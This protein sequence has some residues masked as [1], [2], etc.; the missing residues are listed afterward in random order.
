MT[1]HTYLKLLVEW[2]E[3]RSLILSHQSELFAVFAIAGTDT[4][5]MFRA[6]RFLYQKGALRCQVDY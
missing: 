1:Y 4:D 5:K 6:T 2:T 3:S